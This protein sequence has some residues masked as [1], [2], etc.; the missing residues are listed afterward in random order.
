L[1]FTEE[2][3]IMKVLSGAAGLEASKHVEKQEAATSKSVD[4]EAANKFDPIIYFNYSE[5][6]RKHRVRS[7]PIISRPPRLAKAKAITVPGDARRSI[8]GHVEV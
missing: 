1:L 4:E 3:A 6:Y 2:K 8:L 5:V 7:R